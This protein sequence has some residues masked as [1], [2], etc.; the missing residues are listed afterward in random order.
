MRVSWRSLTG[1]ERS[2]IP[3]SSA[4]AVSRRRPFAVTVDGTGHAY[5]TGNTSRT[6]FPT[7]TGA[8]QTKLCGWERHTAVWTP[9]SRN[10]APDGSAL[11]YSLPGRARG[12]HDQLAIF[13]YDY[14]NGIAIDSRRQRL[15]DRAD[16]VERFPR[17]SGRLPEDVGWW[18]RP[19]SSSR[20]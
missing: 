9:S 11:V 12:F 2:S 3:P 5:V 10:S 18:V 7:T 8:F 20:S 6:D 14:G 13:G 4:E 16:T 15:R 1:A 19:T 17:D